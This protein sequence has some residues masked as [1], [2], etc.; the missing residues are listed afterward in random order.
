MP[1]N[2]QETGLET[3]IVGWLVD[4]NR[5]EQGTNDDYNQEYAIDE[6][7]LFRFLNDT[8]PEYM[9]EPRIQDTPAE[10][11]KFLDRLSKK[12][13]D[14]GVVEI[15]RKGFKYKHRTL[16]M[17]MVVPSAGNLAAATLYD[18]NIFSV[19]RQLRY[20]SEYGR[21]ALD[22][23]VFI[24]GLPLMTFE[25]KNQ[26]TKQN[27]A[28]AE[29]QYKKDRLPSELLFS[30]KRCLVHFA[31]DD[32]EVRMCT[33]LKGN[34]SF[35]LPF[36][37]GF[38]NGA[39]NPLNPDG[40]K[41][42]YLWKQILTKAEISNIL[43]NYAQI[44]EEKDEDTGHKTFK[45]IFPRYHQLDVVKSLLSD[46]ARDGAGYR[47]LIQHSAGSGKSNSIAWLAHQLVT[48]KNSGGQVFD[49]VIVVTDR[50]NLDKQIKNTIRQFMQVSSTVGWATNSAELKKLLDESKKIIIT[51]VHKFQFILK[52]ITEVHKGKKF[53]IIIDEAH[54]SQNGSLSAK[55]NI[56]LSG[57]MYAD[58]DEL[59]DKINTLIEGKKMA[60]NASYFSFT[61]TPKNKTLEMFGKTVVDEQGNPILNED[62]TKRATPHYVYTM[63]QAIE[64]KFILDVLKYYTPYQSYYRIVKTAEDNPLFDKKRAQSVLRSYVENQQVAVREKASII[65]EH[66]HNSVK[67]KINGQGRAMVVT[68]GIHRAIEYYMAITDALKGRRSQYKAIIAFSG[69]ADYNGVTL[70]EAK[71]N[72]FPSAQIEK[73]FKHDPYRIL[74]VAD[75]FQTGY[76]EPLLHTMYVDKGLTDIKA[77]Q[78][79]SRLN[80]CHNGKNDVFVSD[81]ANNPADIQAAFEKYC[82]TTVLA[83]ETDANKLNDLIDSMEPMQIYTQEQID[84]L[85]GLY[86]S[87]AERDKL[88]PIID[89]CVEN[90]KALDLE[91]QIE[92]KSNAKTFVRTYNFLSSI[93]PYGSVEWEKLS[94]FLTLL[95]GKLPRPSSNDDDIYKIV[96]NVDLESYRVVAQET[97]AISLADEDAEI[98]AIPVKTDVGIPV[99]ELDTLSN[100]IAMFHDIWGNCEW[101]DADK[102]KKQIE[103]LPDIVSRDEAYQNAMRYSDAQNA[104][105]ESDRA[106]FEAILKTMSSGMELYTAFQN[107]LRNSNNQSFKKWLLDMVFNTTYKPGNDSE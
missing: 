17:Y 19:T 81:F 14:S 68:N 34:K 89:V 70:N 22:L 24:N 25:L 13:S 80:R 49:T 11:K 32:N 35:F 9:K 87:N 55:M 15:L 54:S 72:G 2:T 8:Q 103:E 48:L 104:R 94:I 73:K 41:T 60:K 40:I 82:K 100:I 16:E 65:V 88:D 78:T 101:T 46:A 38:N 105:D 64:E 53:A 98:N 20:S 27:S 61:A 12:L 99:P 74:V 95:I 58:N 84:T 30:F 75:K 28:D 5:Y 21:L 79:L 52:D 39:G 77:V 85:V 33:E 67:N 29:R 10:K 76:D 47:Y 56:V 91:D 92:F 4:E 37:K 31:V 59:E 57:N 23:C 66:F 97:M 93:L 62:G 7:R 43:E 96:E 50:I 102:I 1:S 90:Y 3:L 106:V 45:Q 42:D 44:I 36:N 51:I 18:K 69:D 86:L 71:I 63:K 107:D 6:V 26:L 83:G